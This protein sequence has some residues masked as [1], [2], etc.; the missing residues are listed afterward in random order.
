MGQGETMT[1]ERMVEHHTH[2]KEIHGFDETVWLKNGEHEL[3]HR[4]LRKAGKCNVSV[5][6]LT[7]ISAAAGRRTDKR[8]EYNKNYSKTNIQR[9]DFYDTFG[10]RV[11]L[12]ERISYNHKLGSVSYDAYFNAHG[13]SKLPIVDID[14]RMVVT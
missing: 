2:L 5:E 8:K 12:H 3:L 11:R 7:K 13:T 1:K 14:N 9:I 10:P 6:E 4:R